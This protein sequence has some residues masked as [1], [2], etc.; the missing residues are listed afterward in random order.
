MRTVLCPT[1]EGDFWD[2]VSQTYCPTCNGLAILEV[3]TEELKGLVATFPEIYI[4]DRESHM[5]AVANAVI[6]A[7]TDEQMKGVD[8]IALFDHSGS[9]SRDSIRFKGK[10]RWEELQED[11]ES[12]CRTAGKYDSDGITVITYAGA[13]NVYDGV[14]IDRVTKL[15]A[16]VQPGGTTNMADAFRLAFEKAKASQKPTVIIAFTDGAPDSSEE[17]FNVINESGSKLGR[18]KVGIA[19]VQV[20]QERDAKT[21]LESLNSGLKVDIVGVAPQDQVLSL[22]QLGWLAQN[23]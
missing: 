21:F 9:M 13:A 18:P 17:V 6:Q 5:N 11:A 8:W 10:T 2:P 16:E 15:F 12:L 1:C 14:T 7:L 3:T 4:D 20:G 22:G 23:A 19:F